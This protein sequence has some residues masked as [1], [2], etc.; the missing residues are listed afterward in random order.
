VTDI[1][2]VSGRIEL[3]LDHHVAIVASDSY[4]NFFHN[5]A[6]AGLRVT[7]GGMPDDQCGIEIQRR[8]LDPIQRNLATLSTTQ[9]TGQP[10]VKIITRQ[11]TNTSTQQQ[12]LERDN[13]YFFTGTD[14]SPFDGTTN[15]CTFNSPCAA[16]QFTQ[17]NVNIINGLAPGTNFFFNPGT[18]PLAGA[19]TLNNGQS[20]FGRT[21]DFTLPASPGNL[22][23]FTGGL[24]LLG[25][26]T[27]DSFELIN[28]GS[29]TTGIN[30]NGDNVAMNNI[31][32]GSTNIAQ[33]YQFGIALNAVQNITINNPTILITRSDIGIPSA[34][35]AS[36]SSVSVNGGT[37]NVTNSAAANVITFAIQATNSLVNLTG[38]TLS[39]TNITPNVAAEGLG[40]NAI[41]STVNVN[42]S[43]ISVS[44][45]AGSAAPGGAQ[46][47]ATAIFADNSVINVS[48][49]MLIANA[50]YTGGSPATVTIQ[51]DGISAM[52]NSA[53]TVNNDQFLVTASSPNATGGTIAAFGIRFNTGSTLTLLGNNMFSVSI[54]NPGGATPTM[55]NIFNG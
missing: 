28:D 43:T 30:V 39:N 20:M 27:L 35:V 4:D 29:Q 2:G 19:L 34:I 3:P 18:F 33:S 22:P 5:S 53:I 25:N 1:K 32:L 42:N 14:G 44:S 7:F 13:I 48:N 51:A 10:V 9:G 26:N 50:N 21:P 31:V 49:S 38:T 36:S 24:T 15:S 12:I 45:S 52:N 16:N 23:L 40:I 17:G 11:Q 37:I 46:V 54:P 6:A 47:V 55:S 41:N 8:M